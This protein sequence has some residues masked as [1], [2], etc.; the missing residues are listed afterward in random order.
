MKTVIVITVLCTAAAAAVIAPVSSSVGGEGVKGGL[1]EGR[2]P[3]HWRRARD[4]SNGGA[5]YYY[6]AVTR[7]TQW[8]MPTA[9][10][11]NDYSS[12]DSDSSTEEEGEGQEKQEGQEEDQQQQQEQGWGTERDGHATGWLLTE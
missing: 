1:R 10:H 2:L 7:H 5:T 6:H 12:S 3:R 8:D 4:A 9:Q 11:P